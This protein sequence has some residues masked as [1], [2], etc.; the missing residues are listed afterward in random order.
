MLSELGGLPGRVSKTL[1]V[2]HI[3]P[4]WGGGRVGMMGQGWLEPGPAGL[5]GPREAQEST[6][7]SVC[8]QRDVEMT[9]LL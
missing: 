2:L 9:E 7:N 5:L 8:P 4:A 6:R 3:S 1:M